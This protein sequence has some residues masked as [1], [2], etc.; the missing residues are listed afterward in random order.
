MMRINEL[1]FALVGCCNEHR[2]AVVDVGSGVQ[3]I[4]TD[5][6][7][8]TYAVVRIRDGLMVA[9]SAKIITADDDV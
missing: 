2:R 1:D 3:A 8:G 6:G 7:D 4:V 9:G 5:N